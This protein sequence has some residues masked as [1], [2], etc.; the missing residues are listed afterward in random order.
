MDE[1][2][3]LAKF[4]RTVPGERIKMGMTPIIRGRQGTRY[5]Y[6]VD[7]DKAKLPEALREYHVVEAASPKAAQD[8]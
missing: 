1:I 3:S 2:L 5:G 8:R 7:L 4:T 6:Y